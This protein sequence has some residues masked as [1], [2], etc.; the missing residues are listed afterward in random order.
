[1]ANRRRPSYQPSISYFNIDVASGSKAS[2][3]HHAIL[4]PPISTNNQILPLR[5]VNRQ[6]IPV[7]WMPTEKRKSHPFYRCR[8]GRCCHRGGQPAR[9]TLSVGISMPWRRSTVGRLSYRRAI[10]ILAAVCP[11][12]PVSSTSELSSCSCPHN[13]RTMARSPISKPPGLCIGCQNLS[14]LGHMSSGRIHDV[15]GS[16]TTFAICETGAEAS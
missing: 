3:Y 14:Q 7:T 10:I 15:L 4:T 16:P 11:L 9:S 12:F 1:M 5:L 2:T 6:G 13:G 8:I